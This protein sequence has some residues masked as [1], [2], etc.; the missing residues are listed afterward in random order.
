MFGIFWNFFF[1]KIFGNF[2]SNHF[3]ENMF[4]KFSRSKHEKN[5]RI[6][7]R[8]LLKLCWQL[9]LTSQTVRNLWVH[10]VPKQEIK[11]NFP[12]IGKRG[13]TRIYHNPSPSRRSLLSCAHPASLQRT[14]PLIIH[15]QR[16]RSRAVRSHDNEVTLVKIA[17]SFSKTSLGKMK[18]SW[19]IFR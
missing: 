19:K 8:L 14:L 12:N 15:L 4:G 18:K 2:L 16:W 10:M 6:L 13:N 1:K 5:P 11:S 3:L 9:P 17:I 7:H